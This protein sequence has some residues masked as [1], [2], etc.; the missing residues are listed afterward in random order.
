M[1]A[2]TELKKIFGVGPTGAIISFLLLAVFVWADS[3]ITLPVAVDY[4]GIVK[5]TGILFVISGLALH[6]WSFLTLRNW[7]VDNELC[8]KGPFKYFR[9]PMYA[10]WITFVCP[11]L[12]LYLNSWFYIFWVL[13]LHPV[14]HTLVVKEETIMAGTFEETYTDYA[15]KTGRFFPK[16]LNRN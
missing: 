12:A 13:L 16:I 7:W 9:H 1:T 8:T 14:W 10:A 2:Q 5:T 6:S 3:W 4:T 15:K 11:G